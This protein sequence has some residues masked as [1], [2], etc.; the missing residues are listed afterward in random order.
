MQVILQKSIKSA[1]KKQVSSRI[2]HLDCCQC[3]QY[4]CPNFDL[5]IRIKLTKAP[6]HRDYATFYCG[7]WQS[8]NCPYG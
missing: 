3:Q 8:N 4:D 1:N 5:I 6:L 7:H 2:Y